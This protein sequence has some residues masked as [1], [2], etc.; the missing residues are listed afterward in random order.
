M[1]RKCRKT[2]FTK[3]KSNTNIGWRLTVQK[4]ILFI[5]IFCRW[6]SSMFEQFRNKR[7]IC[8][9]AHSRLI[10]LQNHL[11]K[12]QRYHGSE[13]KKWQWICFGVRCHI[14]SISS[15]IYMPRSSSR[16]RNGI[17]FYS[18]SSNVT[19]KSALFSIYVHVVC[20]VSKQT[21]SSILDLIKSN[22]GSISNHKK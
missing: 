15:K 11:Y 10:L 1:L 8:D 13:T 5:F 2:Y 17:K 18:M 19:L 16:H 22:F 21:C 12:V 4:Y 7:H 6:F 14:F 20:P 9:M 3:P